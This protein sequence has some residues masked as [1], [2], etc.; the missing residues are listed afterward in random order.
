[1][2]RFEC[3]YL[4]GA[5]ESILRALERA[6]YEQS[7]G[8]GE[9]EYCESA[10]AK[11][12]A[13]TGREDAGVHFLTGGTQANLTVIAAA[14][15]PHR[16]V[17][18]ADTGHIAVH[19]SGAIEATGHKV[20]TVRGEEGKIKAAQVDSYAKAHYG[21]PT[22]EH[23]VQPGMVYISQPTEYG[24][25]YSLKE[26]E[27]ISRACKD[28]NM[29]LYV[30]GARLAYALAC[31]GCDVSLKDLARLS[32]AFYIGGTKAGA[33]LGEAVVITNKDIQTDFRY[34]L[35]QRGGMLA[36]GRLLGIQF[37]ALFT[38]DLYTRIARHAIVQAARIRDA[39]NSIGV[40]QLIKSPT[41]QLFPILK[42]ADVAALE[43]K[44]SFS[45]WEKTG[46]AETAVRICTSWA[47][48]PEHVSELIADMLSLADGR[49]V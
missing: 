46:E 26:L 18:S 7:K 19:E 32:D 10:R 47:T 28:N 45:H 33:L 31:D 22:F 16:G 2:I 30:D 49:N 44:Y 5:Q 13:A 15:R 1:M 14:L 42:D 39:L 6:N 41:N 24:T 21:D 38:D 36:K 37:D 48:K 11:I 20:L 27:D 17:L 40:R 4:E 9:D 12:R 23:M 34:I 25:V 35:K 3:D 43:K 29:Y 8:Y